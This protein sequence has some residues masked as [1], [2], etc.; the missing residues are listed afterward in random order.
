M[1]TYIRPI[2]H[3]SDE[4]T[5]GQLYWHY[6]VPECNAVSATANMN[7]FTPLNAIKMHFGWDQDVVVRAAKACNK[8]GEVCIV[9]LSPKL[10]LVPATKGQGDAPFLIS[11]LIA[12]V[13]AAQLRNLH[14][15]HF[16]FI[17]GHMPRGELSSVFRY[18]FSQTA[19]E[20]LSRL[21][22]DVDSRIE[23]EF[24]ELFANAQ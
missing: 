6:Q 20:W 5:M 11:D 12:A 16:G 17:Q 24:Y 13:R 18:L 8:K 2:A 7:G 4:I 15:T 9:D 22:I 23:T 1:E 21:V 14:F 3:S 19:T 10:L